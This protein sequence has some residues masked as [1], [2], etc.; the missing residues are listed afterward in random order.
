VPLEGAA[1]GAPL[2]IQVAD[3]WHL[4]HNLAGHAEKEVTRHHRCLNAPD[5]GPEPGLPAGAGQEPDLQAIAAAA[6]QQ[7]TGASVLVTRTTER[8]EAVQ[9]L[10]S[11]G[12]GIT[13]IMR[14]LGLSKATVHRFTRAASLDELLASARAG[15]PSILDA[16]KPYLHKR[17]NEGCTSIT[18]LHAEITA[19]G[20]R[21]RCQTTREYLA[22]FRALAAAPPAPP[23]RARDI[24]G[25]HGDRLGA[26]TAAASAA[27]LPELRSFTTGIK[28]DY[29]AVLAG[30][31]LP[32]N[33]GAV[34][35]NVNRIKMIK[36]QMYGRATFPLLRKRVLLTT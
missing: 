35:G 23:P 21:G 20:Y 24:T 6:A 19:R 22:P 3:R 2:A 36:R 4:W 17:W 25:L 8:H 32:Y 12:K 7:R 33:S 27:G 16:H 14:E 30:L 1:C 34:E 18:R 13:A 5:P 31:T 15:R 9:A 29:N 10:W 26:W 11:Q 28:N